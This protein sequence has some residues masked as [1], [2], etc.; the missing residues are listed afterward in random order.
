MKGIIGNKLVKLKTIQ[1]VAQSGPTGTPA[2]LLVIDTDTPMD[3]KSAR[4]AEQHMELL[5]GE[6]VWRHAVVVLNAGIWHAGDPTAPEVMAPSGG[7]LGRIVRKC[8]GR[9]HLLNTDQTHPGQV[10]R[11]L[12]RAERMV[13]G[14]GGGGVQGGRRAGAGR[15]DPFA[16]GDGEGGAAPG[17]RPRHQGAAP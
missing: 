7:F 8:G 10:L 9:H 2:H 14:N 11:L 12:E 5:G 17:C 1:G 16:G 15:R 13:E 3:E 4:A 6:A